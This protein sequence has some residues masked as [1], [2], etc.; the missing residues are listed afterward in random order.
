M[1][2]AEEFHALYQGLPR[3]HGRYT[4]GKLNEA[5]GKMDGRA[6]TLLEP[7]TVEKWQAHLDG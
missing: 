6:E 3:A 7:T 5:K 1:N 4:L 2:L